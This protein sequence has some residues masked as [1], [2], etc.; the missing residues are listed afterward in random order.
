MPS[1]QSKAHAIM[2]SFSLIHCL[3]RAAIL[4]LTLLLVAAPA[5]ARAAERD[6]DPLVAEIQ[7]GLKELGY[8][9]GKVDG[10]PGPNT[11]SAIS[12]FQT[13][14]D[15][16]VTGEASAKLAQRIERV[17]FQRS[18][19]A[20]RMW[21]QAG[22]YI[23]ALGY[24]PG[25]GGFDTP[26]ARAALAAFARDHPEVTESRF[27]RTLSELIARRAREVPRARIYLCHHYMREKAYSLALP[28]CRRAAAVP[29]VDARY[30]VGW[31]YYYGRGAEQ[32]YT[33]AFR[34]YQ[35]AA[36]AGHEKAQIYLGL[37]YR[38]GQ[39]VEKDPD[40][41]MHWYEQAVQDTR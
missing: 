35:A 36:E 33:R 39:G 1:N 23:R 14:R 16:P 21:R 18:E 28:W 5:E 30:Y 4:G 38:R 29:D 20:E 27:D 22:L 41:A 32:S 37:M 26:Q 17:L 6:G 25:E 19:A 2:P 12:A 7:A 15:L 13:N 34:W 8:E 24:E 10:L 9:V 40:A 11:R 3:A 31:M